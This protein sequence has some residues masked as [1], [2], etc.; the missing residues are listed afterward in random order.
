[1]P[2]PVQNPAVPDSFARDRAQLVIPADDLPKV[3]GCAS[4]VKAGTHGGQG[5][6]GLEGKATHSEDSQTYEPRREK[7]GRKVALNAWNGARRGSGAEG[8]RRRVMGSED[9]KEGLGR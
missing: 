8:R 2:G 5:I 1:M 7:K 4:S 6:I 9:R 3:V